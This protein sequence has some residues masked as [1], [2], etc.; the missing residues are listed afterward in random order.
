MRA[1]LFIPLIAS[2]G[3]LRKTEYKCTD[4]TQCGAGGQCED[5]GF[6]SFADGDCASG[7]KYG[8]FS[9]STYSGECVGGTSGQL[10]GGTD[11][12][13]TDGMM[14]DG[15]MGNCPGTYT[16]AGAHKYRVITN[17][18]NWAAHETDCDNDTAGTNTYLAS[19][20][21]QT[22]LTAI[23][24]AAAQARIWVG[25]S[26][27]TEGTYAKTAGGTIPNNDPM[28]DSGEPNDNPVVGGGQGDCVSAS[29]TSGKLADDNCNVSYPAVCE[30]EP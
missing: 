8:E 22:E 19:P 13:M 27:A 2:A 17:G 5:T 20:D 7:R 11:G 26:D 12:P 3:C 14:I 23:I 6:C 18:A 15:M 1:V 21:D 10:D 4:T 24:A 25:V 16:G 30:C 9:G 28:W 29:M